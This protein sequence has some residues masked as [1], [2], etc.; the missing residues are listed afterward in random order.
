MAVVTWDRPGDVGRPGRE[1]CRLT[2][3]FTLRSGPVASTYFDKYL[4]KG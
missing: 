2:G 1:L 4:F 3:D